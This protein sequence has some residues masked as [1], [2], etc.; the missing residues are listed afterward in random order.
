[1]KKKNQTYIPEDYWKEKDET[2][3]SNLFHVKIEI[4]YTHTKKKKP[5]FLPVSQTNIER[6]RTKG[7]RNKGRNPEGTLNDVVM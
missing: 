1:M 7:E 3:K 6:G 4:K 2:I 5:I